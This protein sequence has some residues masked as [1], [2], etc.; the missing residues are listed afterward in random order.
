MGGQAILKV[1]EDPTIKQMP[2]FDSGQIADERIGCAFC[3]TLI[4]KAE[5]A[6]ERIVCAFEQAVSL[7]VDVVLS[8]VVLWV[9]GRCRASCVRRH[10]E[11][12]SC[13][14]GRSLAVDEH[15]SVL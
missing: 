9:L 2:P 7:M 4:L 10:L 6:A 5:V 14:F 15:K 8:L 12:P 3:G 11:P 1:A 13:Q